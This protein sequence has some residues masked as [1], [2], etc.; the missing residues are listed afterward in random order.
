MDTI[1]YYR[2]AQNEDQQEKEAMRF[3][4]F[5]GEKSIKDLVS[6][7]F[8]IK[9]TDTV[10]ATAQAAN[11]LVRANPQLADLDKVPVGSKIVI[12]DTPLPVNPIEVK[13]P[14][15]VG[16]NL[17]TTEIAVNLEN[18]KTSLPNA[19]STTV[20][21]ANATLALVNRP[22]VQAAATSDPELAALLN[23]ISQQ[24][25]ASIQSVQTQQTQLQQALAQLQ[26]ELGQVT[27]S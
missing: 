11:S 27:K 19:V 16:I 10:A 2:L 5:K 18:V 23:K 4:I 15:A 24:A 6:R 20:A 9:G 13:T 14:V 21:R 17:R 3:A 26:K 22:E 8:N 25:N 7:L 1:E 12:P